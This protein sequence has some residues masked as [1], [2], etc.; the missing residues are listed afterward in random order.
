VLR[1]ARAQ[2]RRAVGGCSSSA[3]NLGGVHPL[4]EGAERLVI[5]TGAGISTDSGIQDF[6]GPNGLWTKNPDA[7]KRAQLKYYVG[8]VDI[9]RGAWRA[10]V[11]AP[12]FRAEPNVGHRAIAE[13]AKRFGLHALITQNVDG[14]HQAAGLDPWKVIEVHGTVHEWACLSCGKGGPIQEALDRVRNGEDDPRCIDCGGILKTATIS[15]GQ[16]LV[17]E[18]IDAAYEAAAACDVLLA[19]GSTLGVY[20]VAGVVPEAKR[21]GAK[22]VILNS[23]PTEMDDIADE[24]V[25]GPIA[26]HLPGMLGVEQFLTY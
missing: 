4:I 26:E 19:V 1:H 7:E 25:R 11:D 24:I 15:F 8:D 9:R 20:P 23:H 6:R 3:P 16:G 21:R 12:Y 14:L 10:R 13:R 18:V 17:P 5:L 22:V 2:D